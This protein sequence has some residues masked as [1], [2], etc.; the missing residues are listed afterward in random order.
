[1]LS[2]FGFCENFEP[3]QEFFNDAWEVSK[4][5]RLTEVKPTLS[6]RRRRLP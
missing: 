1:M 5:V 6:S 2:G 4:T 3:P